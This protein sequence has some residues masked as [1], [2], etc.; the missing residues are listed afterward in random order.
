MSMHLICLSTQ[1][2]ESLGDTG[3]AEDG[4]ESIKYFN[5]GEWWRDSMKIS[6]W[7]SDVLFGSMDAKSIE[8]LFREGGYQRWLCEET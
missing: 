5:G 3:P 1:E 4:E 2:I 6:Y 7:K 8:D